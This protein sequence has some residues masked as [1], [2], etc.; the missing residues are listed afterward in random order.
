M[1]YLRFFKPRAKV[2]EIFHS[3]QGEG[4][5]IGVAQ[6]FIRFYGCSYQ[7]SWCDTPQGREGKKYKQYES[8]ALLNEVISLGKKVH[9]VS[10][11][12]GEPLEQKDFLKEFLPL[13]KKN[14]LKVYLETNGILSDAMR[15]I[16]EYVDIV[17]M[18]IKLPSSAKQGFFWVEHEAFLRAVGRKEV[19]IKVVVSSESSEEDIMGAAKLAS[20]INRDMIFI[21]QPN[22]FDMK[23]GVGQKCFDVQAKCSAYLSDVRIIP[24]AHKIMG[25]K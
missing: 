14:N 15:E 1:S 2:V 5:Y 22:Y 7:C 21:L 6:I 23:S 12:G 17:A 11:T 24:Q 8:E 16:V 25:L 3:V 9:S 19:F 18:D 4:K 10:L 13:L 20:K